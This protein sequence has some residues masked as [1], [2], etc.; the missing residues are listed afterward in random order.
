MKKSSVTTKCI[1][2]ATTCLCGKLLLVEG[3]SHGPTIT[4]PPTTTYHMSE[5]WHKLCLL[6]WH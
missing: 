6:L 1:I 4:H 5:L 3:S 2:C